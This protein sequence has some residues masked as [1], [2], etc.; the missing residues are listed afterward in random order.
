MKNVIINENQRGLLFVD[1]KFRGLLAPGKYVAGSTIL[2]RREIEILGI[3]D[4]I[5]PSMT[6]LRELTRDKNAAGKMVLVKV[7]DGHAALH[8]IDG[9]FDKMIDSG[10]Y[11]LSSGIHHRTDDGICAVKVAGNSF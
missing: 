9:C 7:P 3:G 8:F 4:E 2:G 5:S 6:T 10:I 11:L 1:G